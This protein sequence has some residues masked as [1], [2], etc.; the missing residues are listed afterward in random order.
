SL[1]LK[2]EAGLNTFVATLL[3]P[4]DSKIVGYQQEDLTQPSRLWTRSI[5]VPER[6][7]R[8]AKLAAA[9]A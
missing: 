9:D 4:G 2:V 8:L 5:P 3:I 6:N 1:R 7:S